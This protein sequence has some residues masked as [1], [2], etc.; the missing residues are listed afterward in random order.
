[1]YIDRKCTVWE[2]M[3]FRDKE[4]F[5]RAIEI[6]KETNDLDKV[7]NENFQ[8]EYEIL[9]DTMTE[10]LLEENDNAPTIEAYNKGH[11]IIYKNNEL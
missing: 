4:D 5:D 2:R 3:E 10:M 11:E 1:M 6:L 8:I 9:Y 7:E